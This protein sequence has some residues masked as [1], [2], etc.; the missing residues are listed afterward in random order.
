MAVRDCLRYNELV[1]RGMAVWDMKLWLVTDDKSVPCS[2]CMA[3]A[4]LHQAGYVVNMYV[5]DFHDDS[6]M[7]GPMYAL[8]AMRRG[9]FLSAFKQANWIPTP[10]SS[11]FYDFLRELEAE[12]KADP[13]YDSGNPSEYLPFERY[14]HYAIKLEEFGY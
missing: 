5:D 1:K 4:V 10:S 9:A 11:R 14:I 8:D 2:A 12:F 6:N 13:S 3:G 7:R